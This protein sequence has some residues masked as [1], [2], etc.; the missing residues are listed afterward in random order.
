ME[1][2]KMPDAEHVNEHEHYVQICEM[3][4]MVQKLAKIAADK[5]EEATTARKDWEQHQVALSELIESGPDSQMRFEFGDT[6]EIQIKD[7]PHIRPSDRRTLAGGGVHSLGQLADC[8]ELTDVK[9]IGRAAA[10]RIA[11]A[12]E[13]FWEDNPDLAGT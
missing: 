13:D 8:V 3:N 9:G 5:R 10:D 12:L 2:T 6:R 1:E 11:G 4:A 7:V